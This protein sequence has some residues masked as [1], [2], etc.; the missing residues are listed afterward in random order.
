M[1]GPHGKR[2]KRQNTRAVS[3]VVEHC[4][5]TAGV[6]GSNP[7]PPTKK[8]NEIKVL[9]FVVRP[10]FFPVSKKC[11]KVVGGERAVQILDLFTCF[12]CSRA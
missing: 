6:A 9:R 1:I 10:F 12:C 2:A 4:L 11:P 7:A 8:V 3:S 5:H